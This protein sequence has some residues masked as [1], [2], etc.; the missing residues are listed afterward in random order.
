MLV[1]KAIDICLKHRPDLHKITVNASPNSISAYERMGFYA[2]E[3]EDEQIFNGIRFTAM[4]L[5]LN[6]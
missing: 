5:K 2:E 6:G 3:E 1:E 4:G